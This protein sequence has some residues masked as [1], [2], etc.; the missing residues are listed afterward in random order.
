MFDDGI[1]LQGFLNTAGYALLLA[2]F[3]HVY[4]LIESQP[5]LFK[6]KAYIV[7]VAGGSAMI[8]VFY[9]LLMPWILW[10][11]FFPLI[12]LG[13]AFWKLLGRF[14]FTPVEQL[15]TKTLLNFIFGLPL[16]YGIIGVCMYFVNTALT[17]G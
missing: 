17:Q 12:I 16:G 9:L 10:V 11:G 5:F 2:I 8:G 13:V 4:T 1:L 14:D 7:G 15:T 3:A 6:S